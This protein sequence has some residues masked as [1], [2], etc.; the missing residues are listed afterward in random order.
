MKTIKTIIALGLVAT[1]GA[2][3]DDEPNVPTIDAAPVTFDAG[4]PDATV[5]PPAKPT[6]G[7]QLERMGRPA[8]NTAVN[9]TFNGDADARGTAKNAW[10][11]AGQA[12][13]A[14]FAPEIRGNLAIYDSLDTVCGNQLGADLNPASRYSALAGLLAD[15]QLYVNS[16]SGE[17]TAYLG[18]EGNAL[19]VLPNMDCGGRK[20]GYDVIE[21]TYSVVAAGALGG[22]DDLVTADGDG[23]VHSATF[24]WLGAPN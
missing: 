1:L 14:T 5:G 8:I 15:D 22:I 21:R 13:W 11:V 6:L 9:N 10:N 23:D 4:A 18:V 24:P 2:C 17:C 7:A 16:A 12:M 3:G 20:L 19:G